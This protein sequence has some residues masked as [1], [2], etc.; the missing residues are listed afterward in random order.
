MKQPAN[1]FLTLGH[2]ARTYGLARASLLH[3]EAMG[4]LVPACR[5]A[6]GYRLYGQAEIDRL[7]IAFRYPGTAGRPCLP[8]QKRKQRARTITGKPAACA[9]P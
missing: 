1:K 8:S 7:I 6:A 4:L 9:V 2:L 5:S 3:Y